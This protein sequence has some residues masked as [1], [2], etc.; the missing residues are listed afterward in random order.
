MAITLWGKGTE[1]LP[2]EVSKA[3]NNRTNVLA[4]GSDIR[5]E[6]GVPS[7]IRLKEKRGRSH[8]SEDP[9]ML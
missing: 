7:G 3:K 2:S 5:P 4:I 1:G 8:L 9:C 6:G